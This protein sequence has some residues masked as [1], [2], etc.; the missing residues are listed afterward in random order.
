M[1]ESQARELSFF[2]TFTKKGCKPTERTVNQL[3][4]TLK[5]ID[6]ENYESCLQLA[7]APEQQK[8]VAPNAYSLVQAAYEPE[9]FPLGIYDEETM[10]GFLLY[11]FDSELPGW[12]MSRFMI[13][14][15]YQGK[16]Y[17]KQA[18]Q[19]FLNYFYAKYGSVPLYT[20][21]SISNGVAQQLYEKFGFVTL[22]EFSYTYNDVTYHEFRLKKTA[23]QSG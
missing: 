21:V 6:R 14:K 22:E 20:S 2:A 12:S 23:S 3:T 10:V 18:L 5:A 7:T 9:L 11:D 13:D 1:E 19:L 15:K 17:G 16:G 4:I 8:F